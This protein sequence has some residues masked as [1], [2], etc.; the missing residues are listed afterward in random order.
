[1]TGHEAGQAGP[2]A[3]RQKRHVQFIADADDLHNLLGAG[4]KDD[5]IRL[6]LLDGVAV[7]FIDEQIAGRGEN[8][9]AA[10]DGA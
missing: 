6:I 1:M 8:G 3:A 4:R 9:I 7:A 2:R 10:D 5:D